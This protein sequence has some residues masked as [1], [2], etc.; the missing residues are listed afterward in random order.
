[1]G[2]AVVMVDLVDVVTLVLELVV[3]PPEPHSVVL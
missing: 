2:W 3:D 1:M